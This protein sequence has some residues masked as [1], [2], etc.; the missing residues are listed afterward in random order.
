MGFADLRGST[1]RPMT[2]PE[3]H[4]LINETT[5]GIL[6]EERRKAAAEVLDALLGTPQRPLR[7]DNTSLVMRSYPATR[8][9]TRALVHR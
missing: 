2:D 3:L 9:T 4:A 5:N 6:D 7:P 8:D 1:V